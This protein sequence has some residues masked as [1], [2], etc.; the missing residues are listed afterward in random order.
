MKKNQENKGTPRHF[1]HLRN[2]HVTIVAFGDSIT[3]INHSTHGKLN[4][5]GMLTQGLCDGST[6]P[7]G[8]MVINAGNGGDSMAKGLERIERD[9]LR[10]KP[11]IVILS[12]G[13]NDAHASTPP[14][15]R[16]QLREAIRRIRANG[17]CEIVLRTPNPM[18]NMMTGRELKEWLVDGKIEKKNLVPFAR[19]ICDVARIDKTLLVDHYK[20]WVQSTE[21]SCRGDMIHLMSDPIHP[22]AEGHRR[23]YHEV[24]PIFNAAPMFYHEWERLLKWEGT[25]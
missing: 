8:Y 20:A 9:V 17:P 24:A 10:F 14:V 1:K 18:I 11:D 6:F 19:V 15:F 25:F 12:F 4:W 7:K 23:L 5:V 22:N 3:A 2:Q 13:M 16:R 21:S